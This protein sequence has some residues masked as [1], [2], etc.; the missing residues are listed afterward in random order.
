MPRIYGGASGAKAFYPPPTVVIDPG[1]GRTARL[2]GVRAQFPGQG[3]GV[4]IDP[5]PGRRGRIAPVAGTFH[6]DAPPV[7]QGSYSY[8][9]L[10]DDNPNASSLRDFLNSEPVSTASAIAMTYH[11]Y[12]RTGSIVWALLWGAMGKWFPIETVPVAIAQ[13]FGQK[14]ACP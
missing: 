4:V 10:S 6:A 1:P 12:K 11:G 5:G 9:A 8:Q 14:K 2:S 7:W 13:G 3:P